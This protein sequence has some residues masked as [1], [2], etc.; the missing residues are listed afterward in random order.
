MRGSYVDLRVWQQAMELACTVYQATAKFPKSELYGLV[1][2]MRRAAVSVPSNIAEGKGHR[3]NPE[4]SRFLYHAR[5]SLLELETQTR[6][7]VQLQCLS[8]ERGRE[9]LELSGPLAQGL[10]ALIHSLEDGTAAGPK[11]T[12][13]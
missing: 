12:N 10:N 11:A 2:Q 9:L 3:S 4:F 7:A 6:L 5:G 13:D 8:E 1:N